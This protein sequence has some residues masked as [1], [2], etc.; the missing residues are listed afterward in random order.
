V[1]HNAGEMNCPAPLAFFS[2]GAVVDFV[3]GLV[4]WH[5][6]IAGIVAIVSGLPRRVCSLFASEHLGRATT[7]LA[8]PAARDK[9]RR[10][11][12]NIVIAQIDQMVKTRN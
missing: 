4:K 9:V 6:V 1:E 3:F 11:W 2:I 8:R 10:R 5:S 12:R 7:I